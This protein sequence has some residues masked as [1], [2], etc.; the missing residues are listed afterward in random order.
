MNTSFSTKE[1][2][3]ESLEGA[4]LLFAELFVAF[5]DETEQKKTNVSKL[6]KC[7]E[8]KVIY[9]RSLLGLSAT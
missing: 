5:I 8:R 4:A 1:A 7:L 6:K 2:G 9:P 3:A